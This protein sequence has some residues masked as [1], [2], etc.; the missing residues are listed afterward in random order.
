MRLIISLAAALLTLLVGTTAWSLLPTTKAFS[1]VGMTDNDYLI[2]TFERNDGAQNVPLSQFAKAM[3]SLRSAVAGDYHVYASIGTM[4]GRL[5]FDS[6]ESFPVFR[7]TYVTSEY[8]A[9]RNVATD[10]GRVFTTGETSAYVM[11]TA[12]ARRVF[13]DPA[14]AVGQKLY[15]QTNAGDRTPIEI[16]GVLAPSP[17]QDPDSDPDADLVGS[18]EALLAS[19][20][21]RSALYDVLPLHLYLVLGATNP[22][23]TLARIT[24]WAERYFG[25][26][27]VVNQANVLAEH[28]ATRIAETRPRIETRRKVLL[29]FG[30]ALSLAALMALYT[31]SYWY[32]L[33]HRQLLGVDKALGATRSRLL[34]RLLYSQLPWGALGSAL[35]VAGLWSLYDLIPG[36]FL[37]RPPYAVIG[38]AVG[39]PLTALLALALMVSMPLMRAPAMQLIRGKVQGARVRPLLTLVYGSLAIALAGGLAATRVEGN[40]HGEGQALSNQF[41]LMYSL[42]AG[43]PVVDTRAERAFEAT[44]FAPVFTGSDAVE[45][46]RLP[47][48]TAV[49]VAQAVPG[50]D[51]RLGER[52][53]TALAVA[54]DATYLPLM[55]LRL[56]AGDG[57]ACVLAPPVAEALD[58][59]LGDIVSLAGLPGPFHARSAASWNH[60]TPCGHGSSRTCRT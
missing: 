21:P 14:A 33:R 41:G 2:G 11:G 28:R 53:T 52:E 42:Q 40:V 50:L 34:V 13:G 8:F 32:L 59:H 35:G 57:S 56:A 5:L 18:F 47:G 24:G 38:L 9:A 15:L 46:S 4:G 27:A 58:A 31:Q 17:A 16:V 54:A 43:N 60:T 37:T 44:E 6:G 7:E 36:V 45:L 30:C 29:M 49:S 12:L 55:A 19:L 3:A 1:W 51:I 48:V 10:H 20:G 22:P 26:T 23:D 39:I 25:Q